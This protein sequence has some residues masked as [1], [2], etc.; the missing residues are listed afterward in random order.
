MHL[1]LHFVHSLGLLVHEDKHIPLD[2]LNLVA[3][4]HKLPFQY[5][6]HLHVSCACN[7]IPQFVDNFLFGLIVLIIEE[8]LHFTIIIHIVMSIGIGI[9]ELVFQELL[10]FGVEVVVLQY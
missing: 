9:G 6:P 8:A 4:L 1:F 7:N 2:P 5:H 10:K 3:N